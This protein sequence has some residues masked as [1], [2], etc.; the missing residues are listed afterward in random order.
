MINETL[1][2]YP[3]DARMYS[4]CTTCA[5]RGLVVASILWAI[6]LTLTTPHAVRVHSGKSPAESTATSSTASSTVSLIATK[7]VPAVLVLGFGA[8]WTPVVVISFTSVRLPARWQS[9]ARSALLA[10]TALFAYSVLLHSR[11]RDLVNLHRVLGICEIQK[12]VIIELRLH[13]V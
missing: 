1:G 7:A 10:A 13:Q 12:A 2:P 3:S 4:L 9:R 5:D 8:T 11:L 6:A